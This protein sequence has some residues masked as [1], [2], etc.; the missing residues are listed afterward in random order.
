MTSQELRGTLLLR[1][2]YICGFIVLHKST[3]PDQCTYDTYNDHFEQIISL[4][5]SLLTASDGPDPASSKPAFSLDFGIIPPLFY[6]AVSCRDPSIRRRAVSLLSSPRHEG[7]WSAV[8][9]ARVGSIA[10]EAEEEGLGEIRSS[11]DVPESSR[12]CEIYVNALEGNRIRLRCV[13]SGNVPPQEPA[14]K[15]FWL[16]GYV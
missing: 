6:T 9:A 7:A 5:G 10:I 4:A 13:F 3:Q 11:R 14:V 2:H 8:D 1:I 12:L 15:E 16:E